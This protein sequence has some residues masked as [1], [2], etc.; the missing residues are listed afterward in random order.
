MAFPEAF[1]KIKGALKNAK[2]KAVDG[3]LAVEI[4]LNDEENA[5]IG[6]LEVSDHE[7][8][9]EPYDYWD[10]EARLIGRAED[11]VAIFSGK[12]EWDTALAQEKLF[13]EGSLD[14]AMEVKKLIRKPA[15]RKPA[16][17]PTT[18]TAASAKPAP[19]KTA[20]KTVPKQVTDI[21]A[22]NTPTQED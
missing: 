1:D 15:G 22:I 18:D 19:K 16:A 11:L 5:G 6:Y 7:V 21:P 10:H 17:K 2:G 3:H 20:K 13:I 8:R 14:R 12:L 9:V 4:V